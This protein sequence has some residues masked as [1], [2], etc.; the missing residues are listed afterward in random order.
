MTT[1][2]ALALFSRDRVAFGPLEYSL[3]VKSLMA[4]RITL[5]LTLLLLLA[6]PSKSLQAITVGVIGDSIMN[7]IIGS[8][9][10]SANIPW[11]LRSD[12]DEFGHA[13]WDIADHAISGATTVSWLEGGNLDDVLAADPDIVVVM[14]GT[15]NAIKTVWDP[16]LEP[17]FYT[18]METILNAIADR[19]VLL[20]TP[21]PVRPDFEFAT[22]ATP[23]LDVD[24]NEFLFQE[25]AARSNVTLWDFHDWVTDHPNWEDFSN[26]G[27]HFWGQDQALYYSTSDEIA[28]RLDASAVPEP[29]TLLLGVMAS[30][31]LLPLLPRGLSA[32]S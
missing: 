10:G 12:L 29:S 28:L 31:L 15:N 23:L 32:K 14:L 6:C 30:V 4:F 13:D 19:P 2:T 26:D 8:S 24:F 27:V 21:P 7:G 17:L 3:S 25:A 5:P 18:G 11:R 20:M 22:I 1:T 16:T 9:A